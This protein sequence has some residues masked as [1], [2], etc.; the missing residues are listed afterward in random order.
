MDPVHKA[1]ASGQDERKL[2]VASLVLVVILANNGPIPPSLDSADGRLC[3]KDHLRTLGIIFIALQSFLLTFV[4]SWTL[5][6]SL[7][8]R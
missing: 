8:L 6:A 2:S 3:N 1:L 7:N 5:L 4:R